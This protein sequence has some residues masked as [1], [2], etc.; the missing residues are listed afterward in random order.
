VGLILRIM[1]SGAG[2]RLIVAGI[3]AGL[4]F[5]ATAAEYPSKPIRFVVPFAPGLHASREQGSRLRDATARE[6]C[7]AAGI[8]TAASPQPQYPTK[9]IRFIVPFAPGGGIDLLSRVIGAKYTEHW[10]QQVI[11]DNRA[12][13]GGVI[14]TDIAAK[15]TADGY[16]FIIVNPAFAINATLFRKLPYDTL[17]DFAPITLIATQPYVVLLNPAVPAKDVRE[18]ISLAKDKAGGISY[19]SS[20]VGSASHLAAELF[21]GMAGVTLVHV[22][23]KGAS[24]ATVDVIGGQVQLTIQPMLAVWNYVQ[25]GKVR[26]IAVT[27]PKRWPSAPALPTVAE[28]GLPGFEATTWYM[29]LAPARTPREILAKVNEETLRVLKLPDV[30]E[31]IQ[32]DGAEPVGSSAKEAEEFLRTEISRWEKVIRSA[33][34]KTE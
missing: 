28:S 1:S 3:A 11:V 23:Y 21:S 32:R 18:L 2:I 22:P 12:G 15:A 10:G 5:L 16:T 7:A 9:P 30:R 17:K 27:S 34:V 26:A 25:S 29:Q 8:R 24:L 33:N 4:S 14:G 19:A 31:R 20:G 13:A 6:S